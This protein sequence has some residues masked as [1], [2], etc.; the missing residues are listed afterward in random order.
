MVPL[1]ISRRE[2]IPTLVHPYQARSLLSLSMAAPKSRKASPSRASVRFEMRNSGGVKL[3]RPPDPKRAM[4]SAP[5]RPTATPV[6]ES[7][8]VPKKA[9]TPRRRRRNK[10]APVRRSAPM[11]A[12]ARRCWAR[13]A[14]ISSGV[15]SRPN[16]GLETMMKAC[17][18]RLTMR[19]TAAR[20][21]AS[22]PTLVTSVSLIL[23]PR[24]AH[25]QRIRISVRG[26]T[27]GHLGTP[28]VFD[29]VLAAQVP[30]T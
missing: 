5:K 8:V 15:G 18:I 25:T 10:N 29:G 20:R 24:A 1:A 12:R 26:S 27:L 16:W 13:K 11:T 6:A 17:T 21:P 14:A 7:R 28:K 4:P 30:D 19:L 9:W 2:P 3:S 23:T 22:P